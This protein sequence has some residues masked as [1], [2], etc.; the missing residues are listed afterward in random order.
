[1]SE[2]SKELRREAEKRQLSCLPP[3][4][5]DPLGILLI[6]SAGE[7]EELQRELAAREAELVQIFERMESHTNHRLVCNA[8]HRKPIGGDMCIC[9]PTELHNLKGKLE[10]AEEELAT[11][12]PFWTKHALGPLA[13]PS[14]LCCGKSDYESVAVKHMELPGV[15]ICAECKRAEEELAAVRDDLTIS[16]HCHKKMVERA[17]RDSWRAKAEEAARDAERYRCLRD[18]D[19]TSEYNGHI[20]TMLNFP[21]YCVSDFDRFVDAAIDAAIGRKP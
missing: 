2:I 16:Q 11:M 19:F 3:N 10:R 20:T 14:C 18:H 5:V 21:G 6:H 17:E 15:V 4:G 7:I 8:D 13:K 1:M 12:R 9:V